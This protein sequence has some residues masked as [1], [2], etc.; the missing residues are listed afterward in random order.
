[1]ALADWLWHTLGSTHQL[2]PEVLV[3]SLYNYLRQHLPPDTLRAALLAD[4]IASGARAKPKSL[5]G[6]LPRQ[7]PSSS[8]TGCTLANRQARHLSAD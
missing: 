4:Y 1:M 6:L 7:K 3:D 8:K 2:T 5:Q